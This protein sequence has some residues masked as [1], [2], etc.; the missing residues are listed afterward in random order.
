MKSI[1]QS[2]SLEFQR[3]QSNKNHN[4]QRL[5]YNRETYRYKDKISKG[6]AKINVSDMIDTAFLL[7]KN[8]E[9]Q[10]FETNE[11]LDDSFAEWDG[12]E[13]H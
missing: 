4:L 7:E 6:R 10:N 11:N 9:F 8:S 2:T 1:F 5:C 13:I 3:I 12:D